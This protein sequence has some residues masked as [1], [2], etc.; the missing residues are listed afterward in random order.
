MG[1]LW[2]PD[3]S[4]ILALSRIRRLDLLAPLAGEF[5][6]PSAVLEELRAGP[7]AD[8]MQE[9]LDAGWPPRQEAVQTPGSVLEWGLGRGE[10]AVLGLTLT[11]PGAVALLDDASARV[12]ARAHG[13]RH[14]GT[15]GLL[16]KATKEGRVPAAGPLIFDLKQ[17]GLYLEDG[18][19]RRVL[20]EALGEPWP[21]H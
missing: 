14:L 2:I 15:L 18:L 12:C 3:T 16:V 17:A 9:I 6:V 11:Y 7:P 1:E 13:L 19:I 20:K 8:P 21:P 4:V 10:S 5:V